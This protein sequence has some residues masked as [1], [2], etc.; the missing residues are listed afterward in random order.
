VAQAVGMDS[1]VGPILPQAEKMGGRRTR[2]YHAATR[3]E[4]P[5]VSIITAAFNSV[6]YIEE[7]IQ[8]VINQ[9]YDNVEHVIVDGGS[10]DGTVDILRKYDDKIDFWVSEPDGSMYEAI[11]KGIG[12]SC[13]DVVAVLNSD[14]KY[15][16]P[17][18]IAEAACALSRYP[19]VDGVYG[20]IIRLYPTYTRYK[21]VF[22]VNYRKHLLAQK[23][24]LVPHPA[25][26]VRRGCI[27]RVGVYDTRYRFGSDYDFIL[28]C[29]KQG[30][31]KYIG[32]PLT[33]FRLHEESITTSGRIKQERIAILKDH[34]LE[35]YGKAYRRV[36]HA[37]LWSRYKL[38]NLWR[39]RRPVAH[40][41][42]RQRDVE[43]CL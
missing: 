7:T 31:L 27:G 11:N 37:Y 13:G 25:L 15:I 42:E 40:T 33:Y 16:H 21:R 1:A 23:G 41:T 30:R 18:V 9:T 34:R 35:Q 29:L 2:G 38:L 28:R 8:S 6:K 22:Q 12:F 36:M 14:D 43:R 3:A 26:F 4:R 20:D 5:L 39:R 24:T 32:R 17:N 10:S 19:D